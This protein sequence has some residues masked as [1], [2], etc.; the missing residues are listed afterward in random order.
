[1]I[2][3]RY[4]RGDVHPTP[5]LSLVV[6]SR[7]YSK[8]MKISFR[9]DTGADITVIP[10]VCVYRLLLESRGRLEI[11]DYDAR[12]LH[13]ETFIVDI[14]LGSVTLRGV[15]V[16]ASASGSALL[17]L[18]ILNQMDLRLNGPKNTLSVY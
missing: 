8:S 9:I 7:R 5:S 4:A 18:D 6:S 16:I 12:R 17:G 11:G 14:A 15:Q 13:H 2:S 1:M 3:R 10:P